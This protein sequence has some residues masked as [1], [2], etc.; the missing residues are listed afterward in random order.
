MIHKLL[1][2]PL[3][4]GILFPQIGDS[5]SNE[6]PIIESN[7]MSVLLSKEHEIDS[8]QSNNKLLFD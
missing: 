6:W 5:F 4:F 3:D 8:V 2:I 7:I 1:Q